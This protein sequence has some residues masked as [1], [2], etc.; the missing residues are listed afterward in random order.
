MKGVSIKYSPREE[1]FLVKHETT[2]RRELT[3]L[4]NKRF[5]RD[6]SQNNIKAKCKRMGLLTGRT[7]CFQKGNEPFNK[8]M[9]GFNPAGSEKGRFKKGN[10]PH[11]TNYLNHERTCK[12]D[13]YIY[14]SVECEE[15]KAGFNREYVL[16]HKWLWE[17]LNGAVPEGHFLKSLDGNRRNTDPSNWVCL[18]N[19]MKPRLIAGRAGT[20]YDGADQEL[21][22]TIL[23]TAKLAD[24]VYQVNKR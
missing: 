11:N 10:V 22:P 12:K 21:K 24:A 15:K 9:K 3:K 8:G 17:K 19:S 23:A 6:I 13:G 7:G 4:F 18:P 20:D 2:P 16:K 14:I 5:N 1:A